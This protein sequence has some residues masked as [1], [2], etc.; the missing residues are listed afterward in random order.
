MSS[1]FGDF[2]TEKRKAK[3]ISLRKMA[4]LLD[5]SPAYWSDIEKGRRYPPNINKIGEIAK[6]L[7]LTPE[8]IDYTIDLASEDRNEIPMD[9]PEYIK[10]NSLA[11]VALRKARKCESEGKCDI[12]QKAWTQFIKDLDQKE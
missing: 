10:E 4:D 1:K 3:H 12:T 5:I 6:I 9:L 8:E 2:A 7:G 11:K